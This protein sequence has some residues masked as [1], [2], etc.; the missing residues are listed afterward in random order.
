MAEAEGLA[1]IGQ[2]DFSA[3]AVLSVARHLIS[4]QGLYDVHD[5]LYD[6]DGSVYRRGGS[7]YKSNAA[8][9][10][11]G[12]WVWD[13]I[14]AAG[15]RTV[16]A[17]SSAFG[18]LAA[19]DATP[20][21][22]G[23]AGL[24]EPAPA[25]LVG[26]ILF[27][28]G[29]VM[30]AGSR[31]T[32]DYSVG[33]VTV[34][35]GSKVVTGGGTAWL[36]N[37][38]PGMLFRPTG[39]QYYVVASVDS[40]TQI[41]LAEAY[42]TGGGA[43]VAYTLT[44]LGAL[45]NHINSAAAIPGAPVAAQTAPI[46]LS[47]AGR[48]IACV[49][50]NV[51]F[52]DGVDPGTATAALVGNFRTYSFPAANRQQLPDGVVIVGGAAVRD[53][54]LLFTTDGMWMISNLA[55]NINDASGNLQQRVERV[56]DIVGWGPPGVTPYGAGAIV[57]GTDGI[58][59]V[60]GIS[61][62]VQLARSILTRLVSYVRA[63]H[64]PGQMAVYKNHLLV[65]VLDVSNLIV[66]H[67]VCRLDRK[68][69]T[70]Q[71][72]VYA[73]SFLTGHGGNTLALTV[74]AAA[75][76]QR[77]PELI[78]VARG[79]DAKVLKLGSFFEP[80][81][82]VKNDADATTHNLDI[83]TRDFETGGG[84]FNLVKMLKLWYEL[85]DAATDN[86]VFNVYFAT[87]P[88]LPGL[89]KFGVVNWNAINHFDSSLAEFSQLANAAPKSDGRLPYVWGPDQGLHAHTRFIRFRIRSSGPCSRAVLRSLAAYLRLSA[90][91]VS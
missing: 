59:V 38:D 7:A 10:T 5:G 46:F 78:G 81:A 24:A 14:F 27:I 9:G 76:A 19:D 91:Q 31:K 30:Y 12:R 63:G 47:I 1:E 83:I 66:D 40:D 48:L 35:Q 26:G 67:M 73:W 86:P 13:A 29:G 90:R 55:L 74:R 11:S 42:N 18:V 34:T 88:E 21:N 41:T 52:S 20:L 61:Q 58:Y 51:Y 69:A 22:L 16:F 68:V 3:G 49:G 72:D 79:S 4:G 82:A 89:P 8:F 6:D 25:A 54:A 33:T 60:D 2:E 28:G 84:I 15:Q 65:P 53:R 85:V 71:G 50:N 17:S 64:K 77:L 32:A 43:G 56:G 37:V 36:A 87:G 57:A 70:R 23:G 45:A 80:A 75:G 39:G 44:R 62:P